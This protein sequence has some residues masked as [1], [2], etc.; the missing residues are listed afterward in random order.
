M[1]TSGTRDTARPM[2]PEFPLTAL[3]VCLAP[4]TGVIRTPT[5][6]LGG[7]ARRGLL[8]ALG[9]TRGPALRPAPHA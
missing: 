2:K 3:I 5:T 9:C 7:G 1:A 4:G 6:A 8:A